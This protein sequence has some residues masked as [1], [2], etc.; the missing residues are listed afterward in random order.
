M[1]LRKAQMNPIILI[2]IAAIITVIILGVIFQFI[3]ENSLAI[4]TNTENRTVTLGEI[5]QLE[6]TDIVAR[7]FTAE[8]DTDLVTAGNI[9]LNAAGGT[10]NVSG[11]SGWLGNATVQDMR[12]NYSYE[13]TGYITDST[14]RTVVALVPVILAIIILVGVLAIAGVG[15][16]Q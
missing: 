10:V 9:T 7:T 15:K 6:F 1:K 16:R 4:Q 2:G 13:P 11:S 14:T 5:T 12:F 8:N 3:T